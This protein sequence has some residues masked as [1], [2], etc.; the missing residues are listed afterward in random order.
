MATRLNEWP[1]DGQR[2]STTRWSGICSTQKGHRTR[3]CWLHLGQAAIQVDSTSHDPMQIFA[4]KGASFV[5]SSTRIS[6][7]GNGRCWICYG[8]FSAVLRRPAANTSCSVSESI[9]SALST[10][11]ICSL[12]LPSFGVTPFAFSQLS[13]RLVSK[14]G[15]G[16]SAAILTLERAATHP[17]WFC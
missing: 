3:N 13:S 9:L 5:F 12:R 14:H 11:N 6:K 16:N 8:C 2:R 4:W 17:E 15:P 1:Q 7:L 10:S